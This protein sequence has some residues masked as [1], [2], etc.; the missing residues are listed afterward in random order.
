MQRL[1][2]APDC[3]IVASGWVV[4]QEGAYRYLAAAGG[5]VTIRIVIGEYLACEVVW[6]DPYPLK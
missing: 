6:E 4:V 1:I 5:P 3:G 2:V